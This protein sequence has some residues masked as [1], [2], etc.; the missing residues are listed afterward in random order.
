MYLIIITCV[1]NLN[2]HLGY[3]WRPENKI[4]NV[5]KL[6][7]KKNLKEK[8]FPGKLEVNFLCQA[9]NPNIQEMSVVN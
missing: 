3:L 4:S 1:I 9:L 2:G 6:N 7:W 5:R 8:Y